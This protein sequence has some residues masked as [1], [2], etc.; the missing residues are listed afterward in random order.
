[1][2]KTKRQVGPYTHFGPWFRGQFGRDVM[3]DKAKQKLE[4]EAAEA[5]VVALRLE[6]KSNEEDR[7]DDVRDAALKGWVAGYSAGRLDAQKEARK[8]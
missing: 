7:F 6:R 5:Q 1:V 2:K 4:L 3:T 8:K